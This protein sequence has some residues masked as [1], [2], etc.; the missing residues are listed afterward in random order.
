MLRFPIQGN[1]VLLIM[2]QVSNYDLGGH[3]TFV[4]RNMYTDEGHL[5][6]GKKSEEKGYNY[7]FIIDHEIFFVD[8]DQGLKRL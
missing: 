6:G 5:K 1:I 3:G 7:L 2:N 4:S 8:V